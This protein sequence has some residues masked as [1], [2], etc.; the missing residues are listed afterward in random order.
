MH[1]QLGVFMN[2]KCADYRSSDFLRLEGTVTFQY[3]KIFFLLADS[4]CTCNI[5]EV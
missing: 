3:N 1:M 5:H 2:I 4:G